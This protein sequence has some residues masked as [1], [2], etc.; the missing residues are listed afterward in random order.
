MPSS[1]RWLIIVTDV[2]FIVYWVLAALL[3]LQVLNVP[4]DL[5]YAA[6]DDRRVAAWNWSFFPLDIVF[7]VIGLAAVRAARADNPL[8]RPLAIVSLV[9]TMTAGCMAVSYWAILGEFDPTWFIP[10]LL[11]LIWP[12]AYLPGLIKACVPDSTHTEEA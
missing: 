3:E 11:L 10:N 5:M 12:T 1:L 2:F 8:W 4:A 7:S 9:L 6:Y